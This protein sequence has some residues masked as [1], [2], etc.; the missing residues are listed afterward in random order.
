MLNNEKSIIKKLTK[1]VKIE[2]FLKMILEKIDFCFCDMNTE[3]N[4]KKN[5]IFMKTKYNTIKITITEKSVLYE[6]QNKYKK[7]IKEYKKIDQGY[8]VKLTDINEVIYELETSNSINRRT[9]VET[10]I[11]NK[12]CKEV[13]RGIKTNV[14]NYLQNRETN[15]IKLHDPDIMENYEEK[16]F[17][18]RIEDK[19]IIKRTTK[20]YAYPD[21]TEAFINLKNSDNIYL[22]YE[23][24]N[25]DTKDMPTWGH[26]YEIDKDLFFNYN[27][28]KV[29]S[30]DIVENF[31][32]KKYYIHHDTFF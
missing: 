26:Y 20:K 16:E 29:S 10:R 7:I 19:Y 25:K 32:S 3:L 30:S 1:K 27:Q 22:R 13:Y 17:H 21:E 18:Y 9:V 5:N 6:E 28:D 23:T 15:E 24:I 8:I 2:S 14:D 31:K 11:Y 12:Q 4:V